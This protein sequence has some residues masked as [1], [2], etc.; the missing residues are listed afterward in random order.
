MGDWL[1]LNGET[2]YGTKGGPLTARE[3]G[4]T[5]QKENK[6]YVH[7]LNWFDESLVIPAWGKKIK[8]ARLFSDKTP[9][10]FV[11]NEYGITLKLPKEKMDEVDTII[12]LEQN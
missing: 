5:T 1:K 12:E 10:K 7:V 3:W 11:Q 8:A 9:V 2:I 4:V 6:V